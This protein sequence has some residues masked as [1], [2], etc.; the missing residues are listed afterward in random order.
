VPWLGVLASLALDYCPS[1]NICFYWLKLVVSVPE[2]G[3][4]GDR[5][6][7]FAVGEGLRAS[8]SARVQWV[9]RPFLDQ[10]LELRSPGESYSDVILRVATAGP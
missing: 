3:G 7:A 6:T 10:I 1:I 2:G 4:C 8:T 5:W 9:D